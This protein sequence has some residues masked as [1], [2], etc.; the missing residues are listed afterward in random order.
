MYP[1]VNDGDAC[2][3][4][5]EKKREREEGRVVRVDWVGGSYLEVKEPAF[6][7]RLSHLSVMDYIELV[8]A[9]TSVMAVE[10]AHHQV[11]IIDDMASLSLHNWHHSNNN[12]PHTGLVSNL[13]F[14]CCFYPN[15]VFVC[16]KL[17]LET[18]QL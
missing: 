18:G 10:N 8:F 9:R 14:S 12:S 17:V 5:G 15:A 13:P 11:E 6:W 4:G 1:T 7:A 3:G 2:M 16:P